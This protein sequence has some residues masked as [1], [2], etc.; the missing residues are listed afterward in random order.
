MPEQHISTLFVIIDLDPTF[1]HD[2]KVL[3]HNHIPNALCVHVASPEDPAEHSLLC[4]SDSK[5]EWTQRLLTFLLLTAWTQGVHPVVCIP[6][7]QNA[8]QWKLC[9]AL[10]KDL[11]RHCLP[12]ALDILV[13]CTL[14]LKS[15]AWYM[16]AKVFLE[17]GASAALSVDRRLAEELPSREQDLS[18]QSGNS[19]SNMSYRQLLTLVSSTWRAEA[20]RFYHRHNPWYL[21]TN[22]CEYAG[23]HYASLAFTDRISKEFYPTTEHY[24]QAQKFSKGEVRRE[25]AAS[26]TP[27]EA[28]D[29]ARSKSDSFKNYW[30]HQCR[31][32]SIYK[33]RV[34]VEGLLNKFSEKKPLA[35]Y[36][37]LAT[38]TCELVEDSDKDGYWGVGQSGKGLN[39]LG[40]LL[41]LVRFDILKD[42]MNRMQCRF[43]SLFKLDDSLSSGR[44]P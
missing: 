9:Y 34:M 44:S 39:R 11:R 7:T 42:E 32:G 3:I 4:N 8:H 13:F 25:I 31:C 14:R 29:T 24:F 2:F 6:A 36:S 33:E 16:T 5:E 26:L 17:A 41:E 38:G 21:L 37:L 40:Y 18:A 43:E 20:I 28:F 1:T 12:E 27:R 10:I 15:S 23:A 19:T 30:D 22:F 35:R